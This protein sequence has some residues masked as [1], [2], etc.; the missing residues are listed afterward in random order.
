M[1]F[2]YS[3]DLLIPIEIP[4]TMEIQKVNT[5][6]RIL[7]YCGLRTFNIYEEPMK[8]IISIEGGSFHYVPD[9][10]NFTA[11]NL[12]NVDISIAKQYLKICSFAFLFGIGKSCFL[13]NKLLTVTDINNQYTENIMPNILDI[14][15]PA[16]VMDVANN[17]CSQLEMMNRCGLVSDDVKLYMIDSYHDQL[18]N[19]MF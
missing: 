5:K 14:F 8:K 10:I 6:H 13:K 7:R 11:E 1:N 16:D 2:D 4:G 12:K 17:V 9:A 3:I 18:L 19:D 15:S